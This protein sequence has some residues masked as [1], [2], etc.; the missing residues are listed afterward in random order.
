MVPSSTRLCW[1]IWV[2]NQCACQANEITGA[3]G[4]CRLSLDRRRNAADCHHRSAGRRRPQLL[5]DV[6]KMPVPKVHVGHMGF[7]AQGEVALT[8]C[9]IVEH[10]VARE[11]S[12]NPPRLVGVDAALYAFITGHLES[13]DEVSAAHSPDSL[14]NF[15]YKA[16]TVVERAAILIVSLI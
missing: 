6:Q 3:V 9:E 15:A 13:N 12:R 4:D 5:V 11:D 14:C 2:G 1:P 10:A 8:I 7:Q 16:D